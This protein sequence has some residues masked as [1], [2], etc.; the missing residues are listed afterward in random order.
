M[1]AHRGRKY[2]RDVIHRFE[3]REISQAQFCA[4]HKLNIG[5]FRSWLYRLRAEGASTATVPP[6]F[7][8]VAATPPK[9]PVVP[10][11][12]LLRVGQVELEFMSS[13]SVA[14]LSELLTSLRVAP[15]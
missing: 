4:R 13:P 7:L 10:S 12:C 6:K 5:T 1:A 15:Q 9:T 11:R 14:Y 8:E 2:W 3:S